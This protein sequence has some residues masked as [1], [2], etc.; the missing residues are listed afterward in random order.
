[1]YCVLKC[2]TGEERCYNTGQ[3]CPGFVCAASHHGQYL[4]CFVMLLVWRVGSRA[5]SFKRP[6][7]S[8]NMSLSVCVCTATVGGELAGACIKTVS[9]QGQCNCKDCSSKHCHSS[10]DNVQLKPKRGLGTSV[11]TYPAIIIRGRLIALKNSL[12][13]PIYVAYSYWPCDEATI[14]AD[15]MKQSWCRWCLVKPSHLFLHNLEVGHKLPSNFTTLQLC[16]ARFRYVPSCGDVPL[17]G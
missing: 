8:V 7:L 12:H 5:A 16:C 3:C 1:V 10:S 9:L 17:P 14:A 13:G 4:K 11:W 2:T 15:F 6:S